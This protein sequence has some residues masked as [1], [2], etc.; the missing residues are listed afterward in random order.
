AARARKVKLRICSATH[1]DLRAQVAAGRFRED[2]Y[3][4]LGVPHVALPSL[5]ER[6]EEVAWLVQSEVRTVDA[7]LS[8]HVSLVETAL[9]RPWPGNVRELRR[10]I[11]EAARAAGAEG[12][13]EVLARHLS[14]GAG[15]AMPS[16][17]TPVEPRASSLRPRPQR[18]AP[19]RETV[20]DA[21]RRH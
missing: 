6:R 3:F 4:R 11:A 19:S 14:D 7:A 10:E 16:A 21:L 18:P 12:C 17:G 9:V 5:R 2:L 8:A 15:C 20:E 13:K 1:R